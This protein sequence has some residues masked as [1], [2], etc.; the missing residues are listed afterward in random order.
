MR[1]ALLTNGTEWWFY[2]P[3]QSGNWEQCRFATISL[4]EW[5]KA[6][7]VSV[8]A[9]V[10]SKEN[11]NDGSAFQNAEHLYKQMQRQTEVS[12]QLL[13][14][15]NQLIDETDEL[16][17]A[18][19]QEKAGELYKHEPDENE[20]KEFLE[21]H[22]EDIQIP[23]VP[24]VAAPAKGGKDG[25]PD[26]PVSVKGKQIRAFTFKGQRKKVNTWKSYYVAFC[27]MLHQIDKDQFEKVLTIRGKGG[28]IFFSRNQG[29]IREPMLISGSGIYVGTHL[30]A[31]LIQARVEQVANHLE[32]PKPT[33]EMSPS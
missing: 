19:L 18:R 6:E 30:P 29:D 13:D 16:I 22:R 4:D 12:K 26:A 9:G 23:P 32:Y 21:A 31:D 8:L 10:L 27:E 28:A 17:A 15:W 25:I 24:V 14:A 3:R 1:L 20:V 11:V 7:I 2:L 5:E 33:V